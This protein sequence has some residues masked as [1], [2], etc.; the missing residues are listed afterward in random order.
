ML[1]HLVP[2]LTSQTRR[3]AC[4]AVDD[5]EVCGLVTQEMLKEPLKALVVYLFLFGEGG[6]Q[7]HAHA[8]KG[9]FT[10]SLLFYNHK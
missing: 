3:F 7:R 1:D 4:S 10:H 2:L 8:T 9:M 5:D 6:D